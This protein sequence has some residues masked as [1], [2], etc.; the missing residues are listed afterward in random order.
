MRAGGA[1]ALAEAGVALALI[2]AAGRW[3][4]DTFNCYIEKNVFLFEALLISHPSS[5]QVGL[6][7]INVP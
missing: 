6:F 1:M 2:Q 3:S 7:H 5:L 4:M